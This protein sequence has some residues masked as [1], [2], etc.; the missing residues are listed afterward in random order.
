MEIDLTLIKEY[1]L[2]ENTSLLDFDPA[3][4]RMAL[5]SDRLSVDITDLDGKDSA[6]PHPTR[7]IWISQL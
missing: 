2:A 6:I 4:Q 3:S 7:W 5:T 1:K